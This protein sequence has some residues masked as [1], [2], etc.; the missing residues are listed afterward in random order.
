MSRF[1]VTIIVLVPLFATHPAAGQVEV[2]FQ[3]DVRPILSDKCFFCHGPDEA[4]READLRLDVAEMALA[5]AIVP[6]KPD[7]SE[8]IARVSSTD[9]DTQMPPPIPASH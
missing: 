3:R 9:P 2:N 6:G 4:H 1:S 5:A 7:E 8:L